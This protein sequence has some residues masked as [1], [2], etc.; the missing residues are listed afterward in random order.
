VFSTIFFIIVVT[1]TTT[2]HHYR[3]W[4]FGGWNATNIGCLKEDSILK[5]YFDKLGRYFGAW[6][7]LKFTIH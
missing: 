3:H 5:V 6:S 1:T 4:N 2:F 7:N